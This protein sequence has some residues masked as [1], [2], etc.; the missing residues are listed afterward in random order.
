[1]P[2]LKIHTVKWKATVKKYI[3]LSRK[4]P[5]KDTM[6]YMESHHLKIHT[7]KWKVRCMGSKVG[8]LVDGQTLIDDGFDLYIRQKRWIIS[9]RFTET[10]N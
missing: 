6:S 4:Q 9:D 3:E 10:S 1:M 2:Y 8:K 7:V 5:F